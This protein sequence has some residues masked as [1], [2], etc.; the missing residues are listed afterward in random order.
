MKIGDI[1]P[2][3]E[4]ES[5][6]GEKVKLSSYFGKKKIIL[7]FYV[8]NNTPG[9]TAEVNGIKNY[10]P[11]ISDK[12]EVIG[13]NQGTIES[14][15]NFCQKYD[16]PFKI[17]SDTSKRVAILYQARGVFGIYTKRVTYLIGLDGRI[18]KIVKGMGTSNH[19]EF[20]QSLA[21]S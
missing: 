7:F 5:N 17:L 6:T 1:A 9:C 4:L 8:K 13:I 16:L 19:I 20:V 21:D 15:T 11:K 2:D 18:E 3:F 12:Y 14:H 10:H